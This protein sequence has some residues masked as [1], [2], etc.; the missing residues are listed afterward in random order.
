[1]LKML[2]IYHY[3]GV[4]CGVH[5]KQNNIFINRNFNVKL[6]YYLT[7]ETYVYYCYFLAVQHVFYEKQ[8][9]QTLIN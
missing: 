3:Y 8:L 7:Y 5:G 1:M 4:I 9:L 6:L 2:I